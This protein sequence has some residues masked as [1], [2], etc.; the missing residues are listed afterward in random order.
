MSATS[1]Q[2]GRT[3]IRVY[4]IGLGGMP[5]SLD[6]R[7]PEAQSIAVIHAAIEAGVTLIDTADSYCRDD[8]DFNHNEKLIGKALKAHP[9]GKTITVATKGGL[10]RPRGAWNTDARPE[11]LMRCCEA[12]LKALGVE[13]ITL[14][15]LHAP[16][17]RVPFAD[18]VGA[19]AKLKEQGKILHVGLS[20]V[21]VAQL[22]EAQRIVRVESVQNECNP[23]SVGDFRNG[24]IAACA[25]QGVTYLPYSPVGGHYGH[26]QQSKQRVLVEIGKAYGASPYQVAL[27]W[28]LAKGPHLI[29]I[30][31]ASKIT[32][33]RDSAG[34]AGLELTADEIK[35]VD[36][37]G[38]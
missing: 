4:P 2:I 3:G 32:S 37:L 18:S 24:V 12:S 9:A 5:M 29:P 1:R 35:K 17:D 7:P 8:L 31:G 28:L 21:D 25:K 19:L 11:R 15:Q 36:A 34:A 23:G 22:D 10:T 14:Y 6:G 30:P 26:R 13:A 16:D 33:I 38:R 20:N 27:A